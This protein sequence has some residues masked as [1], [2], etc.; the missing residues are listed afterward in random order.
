MKHGYIKRS[1]NNKGVVQNTDKNGLDL[2]KKA[3]D[4][5]K[6]MQNQIDILF[7]EINIIKEMLNDN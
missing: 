6:L 1:E 3:K 7:N 2:Y 4:K 5:Y